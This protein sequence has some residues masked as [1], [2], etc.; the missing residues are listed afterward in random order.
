MSESLGLPL[1]RVQHH[2]AHALACLAEY[3][4]E[5]PVIALIMDGTGLGDDGHIWGG[6]FFLC[7]RLTYRRL[8]HLEYLPLPGGDKA[9]LEPWRMA[10]ACL[11]HWNLPFPESL[12]RR[13]GEEPIARIRQMIDRQINTPLTSSAGRLFDA[14]ASLT[15]VCDVATRQAEA[16][17]LLE[18]TISAGDFLPYPFTAEGEV[19]SLRPTIEAI[20]QDIEAGTS[21]GII[22]AR[23]HTTLA[24][25]LT[26]KA[27]LL[28][29]QTGAAKVV[30]SGGCFQNKYLA[31]SLQTLFINEAIPLYIPS[32]IP[33]NDSGIAI[34]QLY[35]M[36]KET[37]A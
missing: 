8:A 25:L 24:H 18:Q 19:V 7:D 34:G 3:G 2:H 30:V 13:I 37:S 29:A 23:F 32:R 35:L 15:G 9:A 31:T 33:C 17:I 27:R 11:H 6:E 14:V 10:V 1:L 22:S 4:L 20:L 12:I 36:K 28:M 16:P 26:E 5:E 21:T